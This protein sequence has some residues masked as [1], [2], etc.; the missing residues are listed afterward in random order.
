MS[1]LNREKHH[2]TAENMDVRF[3][4]RHGLRHRQRAVEGTAERS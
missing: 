1:F 3:G 4:W 2:E